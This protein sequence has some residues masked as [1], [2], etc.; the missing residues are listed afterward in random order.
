MDEALVAWA[1]G[2][3][4]GEGCIG[5]YRSRS[6]SNAYQL[7]VSV[8]NTEPEL[9]RV[10]AQEFGGSINAHRG[11]VAQPGWKLAFQWRLSSRMAAAFLEQ[12]RPYL[13]SPRKKAAAALG[14]AF[15]GTKRVGGLPKARRASHAWIQRSY[16]QRMRQFNRRGT[17]P[18][19]AEADLA[20]YSAPASKEEQ[21]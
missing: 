18:W 1:A 21:A 7:S 20:H 9:L 10:L 19:N 14:I 15:Q 17:A 8:A 12:V 13:R 6:R 2:I 16:Y 4:D 5:I 11:Q 3:I